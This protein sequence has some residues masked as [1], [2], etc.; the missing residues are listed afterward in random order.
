V[1]EENKSDTVSEKGN[2][3]DR[4][5]KLLGIPDSLRARPPQIDIRQ[6]WQK[7]LAYN[8]AMTRKPQMVKDGLWDVSLQKTTDLQEVFVSKSV[9]F[10]DYRNLFKNAGR[11]PGLV[12]WLNCKSGASSGAQLFG[13]E[14][15]KYTFPD[16]RRLLDEPREDEDEEEEEEEKSD[17]SMED[18]QQKS[19]GKG[20][21]KGKVHQPDSESDENRVKKKAKKASSS[22][23]HTHK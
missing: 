18:M 9:W 13:Q 11:I 2:A 15:L 10:R 8:D 17:V 12:A 14:K 20:K 7:W 22:N 3:S 6:A 19:K 23:K 4:L 16:L 21:G 1:R 5:A